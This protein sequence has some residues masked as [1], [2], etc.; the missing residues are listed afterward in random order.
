MYIFWRVWG[1]GKLFQNKYLTLSYS[2]SPF[3]FSL[4]AFSYS[5]SPFSL[6][7]DRFLLLT[8]L[9]LLITFLNLLLTFLILL[10]TFP[11]VCSF[12]SYSYPYMEYILF[13]P[14]LILLFYPTLINSLFYIQF[15]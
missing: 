4:Y 2:E 13:Y 5:E 15:S 6:S 1:G 7:L 10:L 11:G 12:L 14:I 3:S 8:F 9:L